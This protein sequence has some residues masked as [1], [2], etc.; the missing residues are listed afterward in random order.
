VAADTSTMVY[1]GIPL[2]LMPSPTDPDSYTVHVDG[3]GLTWS[4]ATEA[5]PRHTDLILMVS[6][7]DS[8]GIRIT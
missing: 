3:R 2:S 8:K 6:T 5:Q 1:D 4:P 7:F